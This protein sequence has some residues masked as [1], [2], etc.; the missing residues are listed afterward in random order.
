[1][2]PFDIIKSARLTEKGSIQSDKHNQYTVVADRR[3]SK[4]QIKR[5]VEELFKVQ[6]VG[7][8]TMR[9][10]GKLR[11]QGRTFGYRSDWKKA[12]VQLKPGQSIQ[13]FEGV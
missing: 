8:Q 5:A 4:P 11:R 10:R 6:V 13:I 2:S 9:V 7:V 12:V 3:A 1:M